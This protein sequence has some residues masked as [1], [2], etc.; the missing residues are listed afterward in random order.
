V[1]SSVTELV[2]A[3]AD[4]ATHWNH[5]PKPFV[6]PKAAEEIIEKVQRGRATLSQVQLA[7]DHELSCAQSL[8]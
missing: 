4:W 8:G 5:D 1:F 3:I 2:E 6:W 7:A